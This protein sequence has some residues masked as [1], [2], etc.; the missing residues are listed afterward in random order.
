MAVRD[1]ATD[2]APPSGG[3]P[4]KPLSDSIPEDCMVAKR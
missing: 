3:Y 1:G 4:P 2:G